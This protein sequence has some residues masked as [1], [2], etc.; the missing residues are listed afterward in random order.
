MEKQR[1][2]DIFQVL[3]H[4]DTHDVEYYR[5]LPEEQQ[6][7]VVPLLLLRWMSGGN[8][9]QD[10][11][12]LNEIVNPY[13]FSIHQHRELL[14][15]LLTICGCGKP[16]KY[17][18][19]A[20]SQKTAGAKLARDVVCQYYNYSTAQAEEVLPLLSSDDILSYA[21]LLGYQPPEISKL[22]KELKD[23]HKRA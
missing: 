10:V 1:S 6:K 8:T 15:F 20:R 7:Q 3:Q 21:E 12:L 2:L 11:M 5:S 17:N 4:I 23:Q 22:K 13:V 9:V 18:W 14:F 19:L 16:R